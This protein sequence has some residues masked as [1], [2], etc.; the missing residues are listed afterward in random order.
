[1]EMIWKYILLTQ[2]EQIISMPHGA[3]I[4]TVQMQ[5]ARVDPDNEPTD[6][7]IIT[8]GTGHP[9]SYT[10]GSYIGTYQLDLDNGL[11]VF[12]VFNRS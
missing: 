4:L 6:F 12:H 5:H 10:T 11:L 8:H 9:I 2:D 7:V 3:E 1:M